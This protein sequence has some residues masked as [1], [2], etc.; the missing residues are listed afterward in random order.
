MGEAGRTARR[1]AAGPSPTK[2]ASPPAP[3]AWVRWT[4]TAAGA[5]VAV[6][7]TL[8]VLGTGKEPSATTEP[9]V[10]GDLHSLV[11]DPSRPVRLYVGGHDAAAVSDDGGRTWTPLPS[12]DR[13]D[14]MGWGFQGATA[15]V[16]GHSGL[17]RSADGGQTFG[18][19]TEG[20]RSTDVH[21]FGAG[22]GMLYAASPATGVSASTDAGATWDV[23]SPTVGR[24]FFGRILVDVG[25]AEHLIAAEPSSG[26]MDSRDGGRTWARLGS[27]AATWVSGFGA[28]A[29]QVLVSGPS[30]AAR[31]SDGGRTWQPVTLPQGATIAE[32]DRS[33]PQRLYAAGPVANRARVWVSHDG[34]R[35]WTRP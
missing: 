21:A 20:L 29:S 13:A 14:A 6:V 23:R 18:V 3:R 8:G 10:G 11:V 35:T 4:L 16:A 12:L 34:G 25:D 30:G 32:A 31:S 24:S 5:T 1:L 22:G 26:A 9:L 2:K 17:Y 33:D 7:L 15:W 19:V 28:D 27:P